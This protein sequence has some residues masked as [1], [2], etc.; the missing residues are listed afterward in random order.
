MGHSL[1]V[2]RNLGVDV[3]EYV[4]LGDS[5]GEETTEQCED[6]SDSTE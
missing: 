3:V 1:M 4:G 2:V 6:D 5:V